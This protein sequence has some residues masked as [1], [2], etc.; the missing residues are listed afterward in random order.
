MIYSPYQRIE[1]M[2]KQQYKLLTY[3][4]D[5]QKKNGFSP[6]FDEMMKALDYKSKNN[7]DRLVR[8]LESIGF[9]RS[10]YK[11]SRSIEVLKVPHV[12]A[13]V[14]EVVQIEEPTKYRFK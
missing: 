12:I 4:I 6:S 3:I 14:V 1:H 5:F 7:I 13:S 2:T 9:V 11:K 8:G 10:R